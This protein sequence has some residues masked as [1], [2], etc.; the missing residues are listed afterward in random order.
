[1]HGAGN[2]FILVDDRAGTF[3]LADQTWL[4]RICSR[5]A[6]IGAEGV[7]LIQ[8]SARADF[9][10]RF[11]NPD[12]REAAMC[13]N[14]AR[15]VARLAGDLGLAPAGMKIETAAGQVRAEADG[16]KVRLFMPRPS[17]WK[18]NRVLDTAAGRLTYHFVNTGVPHVVIE[19]KRLADVDV[20]RV[21][22]EVRRHPAFAPAGT[23]VNFMTAG[24]ARS[25][26]VRTYER[27]V[28]AETPACGTGIAACA[29]IAGRLGRVRPPVRVTCAHGDRLEV[30]F[31]LTGAGAEKLALLGPAVYVFEGT[32]EYEQRQEKP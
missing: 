19:T 11:F 22:A 30:D 32:V 24:G 29:L 26:R 10:M 9:R 27:G 13:G 23:N 4:R 12:G 7:I 16:A 6:G 3:P 17:G 21:G 20:N 8:P 1:M 18:L 14:G 28:E 5:H 2:D 15:C 25:L 31:R